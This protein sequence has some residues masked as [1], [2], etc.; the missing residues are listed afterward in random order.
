MTPKK[1]M[2]RAEGHV[3]R[4]GGGGSGNGGGGEGWDIIAVAAPAVGVQE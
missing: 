3:R 1:R 2:Y 4:R